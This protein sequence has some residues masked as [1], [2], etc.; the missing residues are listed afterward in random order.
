MKPAGIQLL[1]NWYFICPS[2]AVV[3]SLSQAA[4]TAQAR[5][6][7]G[8]MHQPAPSSNNGRA[9]MVMQSEAAHCTWSSAGQ[10]TGSPVLLPEVSLLPAE[11]S[12]TDPLLVLLVSI[13]EV[14]GLVV[15]CVP[16][17][18]SASVMPAVACQVADCPFS[19]NAEVSEDVFAGSAAVRIPQMA[20]GPPQAVRAATHTNM[21]AILDSI[22]VVSARVKRG[23]LVGPG[24]GFDR[25]RRGGG[26]CSTRASHRA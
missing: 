18:D 16:V 10:S 23:F 7:S 1:L 5:K 20:E 4:G 14:A 2:H 8:L 9:M 15:A 25:G 13:A 12:L 11:V 21:I 3:S 17:A 6:L 22:G 19:V 26:G 24:S